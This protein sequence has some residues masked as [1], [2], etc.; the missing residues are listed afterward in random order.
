[1]DNRTVPKIQIEIPDIDIASSTFFSSQ[2]CF[3]GLN[4]NNISQI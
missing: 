4:K 2:N 1:M 3:K